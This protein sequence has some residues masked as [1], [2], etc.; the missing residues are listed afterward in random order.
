MT[1]TTTD[2]TQPPAGLSAPAGADRGELPRRLGFVHDSW[3]IARRGL[4][5]QFGNPT[6]PVGPDAPWSSAHPGAYTMI[7]IVGLVVV[8]APLAIRAYQRSIVR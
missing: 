8:C 7:W 4:R 5:I 6:P 1:A 2:L 3:V